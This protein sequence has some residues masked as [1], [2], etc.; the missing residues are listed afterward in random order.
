V[1]VQTPLTPASKRGI[2]LSISGGCLRPLLPEDVHQGHIAGL[3]D[4]EINK[5]LVSVRAR[6]QTYETVNEFVSTDFLSE[7]AVLFG[8][9]AKNHQKHCGTVR[10]H[11]INRAERTASIGICIFEKEVWGRSIGADAI[12]AV[13]RWAF[14]YLGICAIEAGAYAENIGSWRAFLKAGYVVAEDIRDRYKLEG[15]SVVVRKL[16]AYSPATGSPSPHVK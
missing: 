11:R 13:S 2:R 16:V 1:N 5:Y 4:P 9:W 7:D 10:L 15:K 8:I 6:T 3:N 14:E 12:R